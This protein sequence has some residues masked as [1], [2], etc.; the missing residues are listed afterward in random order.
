MMVAPQRKPREY[1]AARKGHAGERHYA[2]TASKRSKSHKKTL[3]YRKFVVLVVIPVLLML[4][5]VYTHTVSAGLNNQGAVLT[6]QRDELWAEKEA[7]EVEVSELSAPGRVRSL[8]REDLDMRAPAAGDMTAYYGEDG[9][10]D[11]RQQI[12]EESR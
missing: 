5:S 7:L 9:E 3:Q 4:G 6:D 8:A 11:A 1:P 2:K 12:Q 10:Q